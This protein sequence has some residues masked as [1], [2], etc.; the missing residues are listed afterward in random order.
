MF[1]FGGFGA[2]Y[3]YDDGHPRYENYAEKSAAALRREEEA[4]TKFQEAREE[5]EGREDLV[6]GSKITVELLKPSCH[7]TGA[8]WSTFLRH[9]RSHEGWVAKRREATAEEKKQHK[10][11][12]RGK[13]YFVD[14]VYNVP[15][16]KPGKKPVAAAQGSSKAG[17]SGDMFGSPND[18]ESSEKE[19]EKPAKKAKII[20]VD[21]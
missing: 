11:T 13:V 2:A 20:V 14:V 1:K 15:K 21:E 3:G 18:D 19:D 16:G 5:L 12:R 4:K 7:L 6:A 10:E 8:C 17:G 9:V